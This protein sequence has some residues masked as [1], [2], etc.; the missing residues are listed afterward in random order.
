[1]SFYKAKIEKFNFFFTRKTY[2]IKLL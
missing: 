1:M 2:I